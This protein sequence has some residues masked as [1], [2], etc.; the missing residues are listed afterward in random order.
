MSGAAGS[1]NRS[2]AERFEVDKSKKY[3]E[4]GYG[5]TVAARDRQTGVALAVK[6]IDTSKM[7]RDALAKEV[8][9]LSILNHPNIIK[10]VGHGQGYAAGDEQ[11]YFIFMEVASGGELFDQVI[12]HGAMPEK[13][14]AHTWFCQM[15]DAFNYC[16]LAGVA[17]RDIKLENVLLDASQVVKVIDFGLAHVYQ[18][19]RSSG[20]TI[21]DRSR[22]LRDV[23]GSKSY[24]APEV[25][26]GSG[27]DG[28]AA[29][30]WSLGVCLFAMLSGFFP[31]DEATKKDWRFLKLARAQQQQLSTVTVIFAFY[32]RSC[33]LSPAVSDL[34]NGLL[35]IDPRQRLTMAQVR[36]HPWI[37]GKPMPQA[38]PV[39]NGAYPEEENLVYRGFGN[40]GAM[41][42][43]GFGNGMGAWDAG[44]EQEMLD[45]EPVYR[46]CGAS[47]MDAAGEE[48]MEYAAPPM[49]AKQKGRSNLNEGLTS[50]AVD[51]L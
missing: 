32:K 8:Q 50:S 4:G 6:I 11:S 1:D 49:L 20:T 40:N 48:E 31:L 46:S 3:G 13:G 14:Q 17:H 28:Y 26:L 12:S 10:V 37:T 22:P 42:A 30:M 38:Q 39:W 9:I 24:C 43:N 27:Y 45:D 51:V 29:D 25:L 16:Q 5:V 34:L 18:V 36:E 15:L 47:L 23:C 2:L 41:G 7:K 19:D 21:V 33:P 35:K 44:Y